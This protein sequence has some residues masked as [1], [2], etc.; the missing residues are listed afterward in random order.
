M[1]LSDQERA[2]L[3]FEREWVLE[4]GS[5][6]AAIRERLG[7]SPSAY[8]KMRKS[9]IESAEALAHEPLVVRRLRRDGEYRRRAKFVGRTAGQPKP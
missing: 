3:E 4:T 2:I 9:L 8:Y 5:K 6:D 1:A 7:F